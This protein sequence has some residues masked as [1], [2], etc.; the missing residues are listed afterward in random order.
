MHTVLF[1]I[2]LLIIVCDF[3]GEQWLGMLNL[4]GTAGSSPAMMCLTSC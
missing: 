3:V 1:Y 4:R 2:I